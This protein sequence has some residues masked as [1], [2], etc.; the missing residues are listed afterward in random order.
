MNE[1]KPNVCSLLG[2][3]L[4]SVPQAAKLVSLRKDTT[5]SSRAINY[6][7]W[8]HGKNGLAPANSLWEPK[9]PQLHGGKFLSFHDLIEVLVVAHF[10]H[11]QFSLQKIRR[12]IAVATQ[13]FEHPYPFSHVRFKSWGIG[14]MVAEVCTEDQEF[15]A[16]ELESGQLLLDFIRDQLT[17]CLDYSADE[18]LASRWWPLGRE[19][20]V[21]I[22]PARQF[23]RPIVNDSA[24]PTAALFAAHQAEKSAETVAHW[25]GVSEKSVEDA[26]TYEEL[27]RAA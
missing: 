5:V 14:R 22:D 24:I 27:L 11:H 15:F 1:R 13:L 9:L 7:L 10:R 19:S 3:G 23:G 2:V 4:Y 17:S 16:F 21:V 26:V 12:F 25:F 6:W 8:P 18:L 20:A